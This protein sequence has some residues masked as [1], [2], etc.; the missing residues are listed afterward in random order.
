MNDTERNV[1]NA[2][3]ALQGEQPSRVGKQNMRR[4]NLESISVL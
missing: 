3:T 2:M 4:V 1:H